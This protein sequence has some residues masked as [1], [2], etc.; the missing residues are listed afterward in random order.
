[1]PN[2]TSTNLALL[3]LRATG[4]SLAVAHGWGKCV[5][6]SQGQGDGFIQGVASLGFPMPAVFAWA[7]ALAEMAGGLAIALGLG[8]R[9]AAAF[10]AFTM[11]V[12]GIVRHHF[13]GH[14]LVRLGVSGASKETIESWGNPELAM[15]YF[16][17]F[18]SLVLLGG[19][20]WSV[21]S[22]WKRRRRKG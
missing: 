19:G 20:R 22:W 1:M 10:A 4:V 6:L 11:G 7:A 3:L 5:A 16:V 12:A 9:I 14:L 15:V 2:T 8:T 18:T 13:F 21:A 17:V